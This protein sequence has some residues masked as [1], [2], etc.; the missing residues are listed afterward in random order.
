MEAMPPAEVTAYL[1]SR[2]QYFV[3]PS[4]GSEAAGGYHGYRDYLADRAEI[5]VKFGEILERLEQTSAPGRLLDVGAGPGFLLAAARARGWGG[6]GIDL[7]PWAAAYAREQVGAEV[8]VGALADAGFAPARFD[9]VTMM[10]LIEH[11]AAPAETIGEAARILRPGGALALL[12]PDAGSAISRL[13]GRRWPEVVRAPEHLILFS[14]G[15]LAALLARH[16]FEPLGWHSVGKTST[17][18][19]LVA[20]VSP[21]APWLA[22]PLGRVLERTGLADRSLHLDPRTKFCLY[23]RRGPDPQPAAA[24]PAGGRPPRVPRRAARA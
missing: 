15:G 9:A 5:E 1:Y 20:D 12:T 2:A 13:L 19:T 18:R 7:N 6:E 21:A 4:F 24:E 14:V 8:R 16:G 3:N 10:D 22:R 23:A 11:L 17:L